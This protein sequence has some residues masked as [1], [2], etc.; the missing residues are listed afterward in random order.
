M[1]NRD[2][3]EAF[4]LTPLSEEEKTSKHILGRLYGPIATCTESTRNGRRYNKVLWERALSDE[5]MQEKIKNKCLFL[6]L[7]HP[8][9]R[10]EVDMTKVCACIPELPK[11]IDNDLYA[12]VD[13]LDTPNGKILKTLCDYGFTPGISSRGSGDVDINN[14]VDPETFYLETFDIVNLPAVKKARLAMCESLNNKKTLKQALTESLKNAGEK[15]KEIMKEA[16][17]NLD[18]KVEETDEKDIP[19]AA[20][21]E[22]SSVL[23]EANDEVD[24]E[25]TEDTDDIE[26]E[27]SDE[28]SDFDIVSD[29]ATVGDLIKEF[30]DYDKDLQLE[31]APIDINGQEIKINGLGFDPSEEGKLVLSIGYSQE[32]GDNIDDA[33]VTD[34]ATD[35]IESEETEENSETVDDVEDTEVDEVLEN[36]K[37]A[38]RQK[39]LFEQELKTLKNE[40]TVRD[41]EVSTLKEEVNR[42]KTAFAR[43]SK[44]AADAT[45]LREKIQHKDVEIRK[46]KTEASTRL[47]ESIETNTS[48][49]NMLSEKLKASQAEIESL[50]AK[51]EEQANTYNK[52][53]NSYIKTARSYQAKYN[54][55]MDKYIEYRASMLG[56]RP[57]EIKNKLTENFTPADIE[58]ACDAVL[59]ES[60]NLSKLPFGL[61]KHSRIQINES[62]SA[63]KSTVEGG[64][65]IDDSLLEL[66]GLK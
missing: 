29:A 19:W 58:T 38:I 45:K 1:N 49:I 18:I 63:K 30:E 57:V 34:E 41:T 9:D 36:L 3:V 15:D 24:E 39:N 60:M 48:T 17:D 5:L 53:L 22:E 56:V 26:A 8:V 59:D 14:D 25:S 6:E 40:Q 44:L 62:K 27:E 2:I 50:N 31:F 10:E 16:L 28:Y 55:A 33:E 47:T 66:A 13:I 20:D 64:Y 51:L 23:V 42:Y 35:E 65:D 43:T 54:E 32:I 7:G 11:I 21:E 4:H 61:E 12:Y 37:E 46:L 52:K